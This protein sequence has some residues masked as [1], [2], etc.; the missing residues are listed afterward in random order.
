MNLMFRTPGRSQMFDQQIIP[1]HDVAT[2]L[3][4]DEACREPLVNPPTPLT[5]GTSNPEPDESDRQT[6]VTYF[7]SRGASQKSEVHLSLEELAKQIR[8]TTKPS[9]GELPWL[10]LARFGDV[11]TVEACLRHD[12]NVLAITGIE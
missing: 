4:P 8:I 2:A 9:K 7:Y 3:N 1:R 5:S 12:S 11:R 10:K 6:C